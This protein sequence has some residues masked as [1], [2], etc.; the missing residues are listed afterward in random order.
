MLRRGTD[1]TEFVAPS[2]P[3]IDHRRAIAQ[4][5]AIS[6]VPFTAQESFLLDL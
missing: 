6:D 2:S 4:A 1:Y 3:P 5:D